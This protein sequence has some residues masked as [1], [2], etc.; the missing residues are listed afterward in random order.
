MTTLTYGLLTLVLLAAGP[1]LADEDQ[2]DRIINH[3]RAEATESTG[4]PSGK[5][6]FF[7]FGTGNKTLGPGFVS[8]STTSN[9]TTHT[10]F[11]VNGTAGAATLDGLGKTFVSSDD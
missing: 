1:A 3:Q 10:T 4:I 2:V 11:T 8:E 9:G 6:E 5:H 7:S